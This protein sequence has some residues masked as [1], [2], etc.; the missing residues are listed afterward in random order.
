[1]KF[2]PD[3]RSI[4]LIYTI[5][6]CKSIHTMIYTLLWIKINRRIL[7]PRPTY[8]RVI[9]QSAY[10]WYTIHSLSDI[11]IPTCQHPLRSDV[12][13][14][15]EIENHLED[16]TYSFVH[17]AKKVHKNKWNPVR[18]IIFFNTLYYKVYCGSWLYFF[19]FKL[20]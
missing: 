5:L 20:E 8:R 3:L 11:P 17:V 14:Q 7:P 18:F 1:M 12:L 13:K 15:D 2:Q 9:L 4:G 6:I 19:L 10:L 16:F